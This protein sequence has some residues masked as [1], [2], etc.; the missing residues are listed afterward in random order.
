MST[1]VLWSVDSYDR[2]GDVYETG[3]YLHFG[4]TRI[5]VG[6]SVADFD[7]FICRLQGFRRELAEAVEAR[8]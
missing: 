4:D 6:E 2:D 5:K 1:D 8:E 3:V 7:D